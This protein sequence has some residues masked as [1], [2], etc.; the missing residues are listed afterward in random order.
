MNIIFSSSTRKIRELQRNLIIFRIIFPSKRFVLLF[1]FCHPFA[2]C[3]LSLYNPILL[4]QSV[5]GFHLRSPTVTKSYPNAR[6]PQLTELLL[7]LGALVETVLFAW[8]RARIWKCRLYVKHKG[9]RKTLKVCKL[10]F[11]KNN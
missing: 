4:L 8:Q 2:I 7:L 6:N 11:E 10:V 3:L 5:L 9:Y 1:S